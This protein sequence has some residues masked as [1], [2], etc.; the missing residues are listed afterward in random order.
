MKELKSELIH[1]PKSGKNYLNL[2]LQSAYLI[3]MGWE[4]GHRIL[5]EDLHEVLHVKIKVSQVWKFKEG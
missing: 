2:P 4:R 5:T 1:I 3:E